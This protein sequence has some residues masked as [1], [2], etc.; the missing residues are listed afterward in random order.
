MIEERKDFGQVAGLI[1]NRMINERIN[2]K[3]DSILAQAAEL[4]EKPY[5]DVDPAELSLEELKGRAVDFEKI[6]DTLNAKNSVK[7]YSGKTGLLSIEDMQ[8]DDY[9]SG[10]YVVQPGQQQMPIG[11][12]EL[13]FSMGPFES[14]ALTLM[15]APANRLYQSI[16]PLKD[17][18][19]NIS[20]IVRVV[21]V[22]K[23][24]VP[25]NPD[26]SFSTK[27]FRLDESEPTQ[28]EDTYSIREQVVKDLKELAAMQTAKEK[29]EEFISLAQEQTWEK[30]VDKF[31]SE[32]P[33][34][35][36]DGQDNFKMTVWD[37]AQRPSAILLG[38]ITERNKNQAGSHLI[39][40]LYK[41][42]KMALDTLFDLVP[43]DSNT[44]A[45]LPMSI[46]IKPVRSY[47]CVKDLSIKKI[48]RNEYNKIKAVAALRQD[49]LESQNLGA[50]FFQ[51]DNILERMNFR[52]TIERPR[53]VEPNEPN[54][55]SSPPQ[56]ES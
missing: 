16:G 37:D 17:I 7:V 29:A 11:L 14:T 13:V 3:A 34:K 47:Y 22:K 5:L 50:E 10:L 26:V 4:A 33:P 51:P 46:E 54:S 21:D 32:Y 6:A 40:N 25:E 20:A 2:E 30:A 23:S 41:Q 31:N 42:R 8:N 27:S 36:P 56:E 24:N 45:T 15:E 18:Q 9:V 44:L 43:A 12:T 49:G 39:V 52:L 1:T 38:T 35:E 53:P 28:D 55:E 19:N 48:D